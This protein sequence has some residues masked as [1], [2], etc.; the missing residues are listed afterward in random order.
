MV[1][2]SSYLRSLLLKVPLTSHLPG[3]HSTLTAHVHLAELV[4][5]HAAYSFFAGG[6]REAGVV[7]AVG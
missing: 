6:L 1:T 3:L 2:F 4:T 5:G 7:D